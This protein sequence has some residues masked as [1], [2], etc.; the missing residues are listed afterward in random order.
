VFWNIFS[1]YSK[2]YVSQY[3]PLSTCR[4]RKRVEKEILIR[5]WNYS[6]TGRA[7]SSV[8]SQDASSVLKMGIIAYCIK[9]KLP[10]YN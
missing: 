6:Q 2:G 1:F 5:R 7:S 4:I 8:L 10:I 9:E 3:L